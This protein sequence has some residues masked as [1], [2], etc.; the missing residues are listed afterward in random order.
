MAAFER[1]VS[2]FRP[3]RTS[4]FIEDEIQ[5]PMEQAL[6]AAP[7]WEAFARNVRYALRQLRRSPGFAATAVLALALGIG[8]NVAIFS[9]IWATFFAP[10]PYPNANQLVVVW[11][12]YKGERIPTQGNEYAE[13]AAQSK[14]FDSLSFQSWRRFIGRTPITARIRKHGLPPRL[15]A[16]RRAQCRS[17]WQWAAVSC[18]AKAHQVTIMW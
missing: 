10:L 1:I 18:Q 17:R 2:L 4:K 6:S 8:P 12:H 15:Q 9:I 7:S 14:T 3:P 11:R 13:L 16:C 5:P